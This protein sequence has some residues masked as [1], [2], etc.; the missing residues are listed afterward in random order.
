MKIKNIWIKWH[1]IKHLK[2]EKEKSEWFWKR[3]SHET[4]ES[5]L[6]LYALPPGPSFVTEKNSKNF[7][8]FITQVKGSVFPGGCVCSPH[9]AV[10]GRR[11]SVLHL[12]STKEADHWCIWNVYPAN[13]QKYSNTEWVTHQGNKAELGQFYW[14][15]TLFQSLK[16]IK[17]TA[18]GKVTDQLDLVCLGRSLF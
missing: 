6:Q 11:N 18:W 17:L 1:T 12:R 5:Y 3:V 9:P 7:W 8:G 15:N 13:F 4:Q 14:R 16:Q 2:H 10:S